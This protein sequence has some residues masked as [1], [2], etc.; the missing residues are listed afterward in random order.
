MHVCRQT[1]RG[2]NM[3]NKIF[4]RGFLYVCISWL[5]LGCT[6]AELS[7]ASKFLTHLDAAMKNKSGAGSSAIAAYE[8]PQSSSSSTSTVKTYEGSMFS[9]CFVEKWDAAKK[10]R[11]LTNKCNE[12][13]ILHWQ[14][15]ENLIKEPN[16]GPGASHKFAPFETYAIWDYK[17]LGKKYV[18][19]RDYL[20]GNKVHQEKW[21]CYYNRKQ[22]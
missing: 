21:G 12:T 16:M 8:A 3:A 10:D 1:L 18:A 11:V 22:N 14:S 9:L 15:N 6:T 17:G 5:M 20:S 13:M 2:W 19:C 7:Q 4:C